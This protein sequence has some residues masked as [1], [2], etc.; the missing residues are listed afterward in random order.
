[1]KNLDKKKENKG[2]ALRRQQEKK[3]QNIRQYITSK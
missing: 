2:A 1:M 3:T